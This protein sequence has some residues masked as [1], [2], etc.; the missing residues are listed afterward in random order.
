MPEA[1]S[2]FSQLSSVLLDQ[3]G[4]FHVALGE[5]HFIYDRLSLELKVSLESFLISKK[6]KLLSSRAF[7]NGNGF[8]VRGNNWSVV[9]NWSE[10]LIKE[11]C[12]YCGSVNVNIVIAR[13]GA[14]TW[15]SRIVDGGLGLDCD[16]NKVRARRRRLSGWTK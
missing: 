5:N 15:A 2:N 16:D 13:R 9:R 8:G 4:S 1:T 10:K 11:A 3:A 7:I 6:E 14:L 12:G